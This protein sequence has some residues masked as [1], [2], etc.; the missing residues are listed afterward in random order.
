[1]VQYHIVNGPLIMYC[2]KILMLA[3]KTLSSGVGES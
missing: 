3:K 2:H 1:M